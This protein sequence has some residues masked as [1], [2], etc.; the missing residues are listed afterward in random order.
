[1]ETPQVPQMKNWAKNRIDIF[2]R[3]VVFMGLDLKTDDVNYYFKAVFIK[4]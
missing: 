2:M 1:M 3:A 4:P